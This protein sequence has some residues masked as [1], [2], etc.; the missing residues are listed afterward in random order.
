[1]NSLRYPVISHKEEPAG[2]VLAV[3]SLTDALFINLCSDDG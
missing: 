3:E 1:M 2:K